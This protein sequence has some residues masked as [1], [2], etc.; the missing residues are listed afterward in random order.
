[1]LFEA[2]CI[3]GFQEFYKNLFCILVEVNK[4]MSGNNEDVQKNLMENFPSNLRVCD[5]AFAVV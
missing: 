2:Y 4:T 3:F 1:M 5:I